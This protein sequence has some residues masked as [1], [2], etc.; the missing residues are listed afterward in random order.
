MIASFKNVIAVV[1]LIIGQ[2]LSK[3]IVIVG[4]TGQLGRILTKQGVD[5]GHIVTAIARDEEKF[6]SLFDQNYRNKLTFI[7]GDVESLLEENMDRMTSAFRGIK[8]VF[9]KIT[10]SIV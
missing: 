5:M 9:A 2:T 1:F 8:V 4:A 7:K 10:S 6:N 3:N